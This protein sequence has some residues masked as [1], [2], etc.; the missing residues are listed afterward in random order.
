MCQATNGIRERTVYSTHRQMSCKQKMILM[1]HVASINYQKDQNQNKCIGTVKT[2]VRNMLMKANFRILDCRGQIPEQ[3]KRKWK[4]WIASCHLLLWCKH[5]SPGAAVSKETLE[6]KSS[7][8]QMCTASNRTDPRHFGGEVM[9]A[10]C[11][12][13]PSTRLSSCQNK[14]GWI[15]IHR[16]RHHIC[17]TTARVNEL[18]VCAAWPNVA[19][20]NHWLWNI[21]LSHPVK[22]S[23]WFSKPL[24]FFSAKA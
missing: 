10:A 7:K 9:L 23:K 1:S 15:V 19:L 17:V 13:Q 21:M 4:F 12:K 14:P 11:C 18:A 22:R 16:T 20:L 5:F 24:T 3:C 2:L 6:S 8:S